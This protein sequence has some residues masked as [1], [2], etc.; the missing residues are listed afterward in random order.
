MGCS[1]A[2][3]RAGIYQTGNFV[4]DHG[5]IYLFL[6]FELALVIKDIELVAKQVTT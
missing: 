3:V 2:A 6:N 4:N 1:A 5:R